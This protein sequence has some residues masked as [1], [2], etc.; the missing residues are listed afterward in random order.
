VVIIE[1]I[2]CLCSDILNNPEFVG[3]QAIKSAV[4][5]SEES[6]KLR[7]NEEAEIKCNGRTAIPV[8]YQVDMI[9]C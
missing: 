7:G 8:L 9:D 1:N 4:Q 5:H 2:S 3:F 6:V